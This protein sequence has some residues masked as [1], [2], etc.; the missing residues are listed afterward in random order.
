MQS[1]QLA[2]V[3]YRPGCPVVTCREVDYG[4]WNGLDL[5]NQVCPAWL[6][7]ICMAADCQLSSEEGRRQL[8]SAD[9]RT[10]VVRPPTATLGTDVSRE[11]RLPAQA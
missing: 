11:S 8:R 7:L 5:L 10:C 4:L 6:R 3:N 9:L 2:C 1:T